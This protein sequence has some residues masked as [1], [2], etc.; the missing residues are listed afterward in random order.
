LIIFIF[1]KIK[2]SA[3]LQK[4]IVLKNYFQKK[5]KKIWQ[6]KKKAVLLQSV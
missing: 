6:L 3:N 2:I 1:Q 4:N 5:N